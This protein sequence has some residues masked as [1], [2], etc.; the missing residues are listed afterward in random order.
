MNDATQA[1]IEDRAR[2]L[3]GR[4]EEDTFLPEHLQGLEDKRL[5]DAVLAVIAQEHPD[6]NGEH[7][8]AVT[9]AAATWCL[10]PT[11]GAHLATFGDLAGGYMVAAVLA[12]LE[13]RH[14]DAN[15]L[16]EIAA[17]LHPS[18]RTLADLVG[19]AA[20][21]RVDRWRFAAE[22]LQAITLEPVEVSA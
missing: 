1:Q 9:F 13:D 7:P 4:L 3:A 10:S 16:A 8:T 15:R 22:V 2:F 18:Q 5:R 12:L 11:H 14:D 19:I 21:A 6:P 17:R 20:H